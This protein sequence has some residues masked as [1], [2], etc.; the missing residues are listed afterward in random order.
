MAH[1]YRYVSRQ[2]PYS[3][4]H[5]TKG[6][7][8][9]RVVVMLDDSEGPFPGYSYDKLLG[10]AEL[11]AKDHE[12]T[13]NGKD[14]AVERTRRLLYVCG[15]RAREELAVVIYADNVESAILSRKV[16]KL[17]DR[18]LTLNEIINEIAAPPPGHRP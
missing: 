13:A 2:S 7:E 3:T 5:A 8:F 15:S 11:S 12:N 4:Q 16:T 9:P 6:A 17:T 10:L 1:P 14:N 18:P